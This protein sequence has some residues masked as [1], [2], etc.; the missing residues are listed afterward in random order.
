MH[1][2]NHRFY[3]PEVL[4]LRRSDRTDCRGPEEG[5]DPVGDTAVRAFALYR[6]DWFVFEGR[7]VG[8]GFYGFEQEL[9]KG[10]DSRGTLRKRF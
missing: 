8:R 5:G 6:T 2:T 9:V 1:N 3:G 7:V 4:G 10:I